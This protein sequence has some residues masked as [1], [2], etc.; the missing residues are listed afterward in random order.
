MEILE[1]RLEKAPGLVLL[2]AVAAVLFL[3]EGSQISAAFRVFLVAWSLYAFSSFLD[4]IVFDVL[5]GPTPFGKEW[6]FR[7]NIPFR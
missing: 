1:K 2:F 4:R 5:Y 3:E 6:Q 7:N